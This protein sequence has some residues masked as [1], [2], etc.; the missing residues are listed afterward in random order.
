[1][2][3]FGTVE[4]WDKLTKEFKDE[5]LKDVAYYSPKEMDLSLSVEERRKF[6][7]EWTNRG[8]EALSK[9]DLLDGDFQDLIEKTVNAKTFRLRKDAD[10]ILDFAEKYNIPMYILSAGLGNVIEPF[11]I[12]TTSSYLKL[13]EKGLVTV[14][15]NYLTFDEKTKKVNGYK[16]PALNT[17]TKTDV[18]VFHIKKFIPLIYNNLY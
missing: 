3:S 14:V 17:F 13:K 5:R 8:L 2:S 15:S 16:K 18:S 12:K 10:K 11:L 7:D 1:M 6:C 9:Q 4:H